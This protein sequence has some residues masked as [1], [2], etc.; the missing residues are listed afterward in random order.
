MIGTTSCGPGTLAISGS[1]F[2]VSIVKSPPLRQQV[3]DLGEE[4]LVGLPIMRLVA[5]PEVPGVDLRLQLGAPLQQRALRGPN[6]C[7]SA[8]ESFPEALWVHLRSGKRFRF[9]EG[10]KVGETRR[11]LCATSPTEERFAVGS[12]MAP[13]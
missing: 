4:G 6:S 5:P 10:A 12:F 3:A 13:S 9:Q 1:T 11:P 8:G 2:A 7:T